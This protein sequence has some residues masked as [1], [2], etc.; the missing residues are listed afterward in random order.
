MYINK[1]SLAVAALLAMVGKAAFA[2]PFVVEGKLTYLNV[3]YTTS[4]DGLSQTLNAGSTVK[5]N[6][7]TIYLT[8]GTVLS[9][10]TGPISPSQL[11]SSKIFPGRAL[12]PASDVPAG[13]T[14]Q[15]SAF[16]G[17]TC[18][19]EGDDD[20]TPNGGRKATAMFVEPAENVLVGPTTN[21]PGMPF[22]IMGVKIKMLAPYPGG[23]ELVDNYEPD[24]VGRIKASTPTNA[25]GMKIR[26]STVGKGDESSAEGYLSDDRTIFYAFAVETTGGDPVDP[27]TYAVASI[28]RADVTFTNAQSSKIEVR[29]G[30]TLGPQTITLQFLNTS[31]QLI[32]SATT[33]TPCAADGT[34]RYRNDQF[35]TVGR[36][37]PSYVR[38]AADGI[39]YTDDIVLD[40]I[41]F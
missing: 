19:I 32:D 31:R 10:P 30:C 23:S 16:M 6:G 9:T 40:R 37:A 25:I 29:G 27:Q 24:N 33:T 1:K 34:F 41:G 26:L 36:P 28:L 20:E 8:P 12:I 3:T 14:A 15:R 21:E 38:A 22:S 5:C 35:S 13:V 39:H 2:V 4:A 7:S 18:I 17:G 11:M